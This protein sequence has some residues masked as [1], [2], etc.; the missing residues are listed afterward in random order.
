MRGGG[1]ERCLLL[2]CGPWFGGAMTHP[3]GESFP[4]GRGCPGC[5][6]PHESDHH[7]LQTERDFFGRV[8]IRRAAAPSAG[9]RG[10]GSCGGRGWGR[11]E[12]QP[13]GPPQRTRPLRLTRLSSAW[14]RRWAGAMSGSASRRASPMLCDAA[15]T[16]GTCCSWSQIPGHA[17]GS[18]YSSAVPRS[19]LDATCTSGTCCSQSQDTWLC[20]RLAPLL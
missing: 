19:L 11:A 5:V 18:P 10:C 13:C 4:H 17:R 12:D 2:S 20:Q 1:W 3:P 16:S 7:P 6:C 9:V 8:V 15:C 14:A